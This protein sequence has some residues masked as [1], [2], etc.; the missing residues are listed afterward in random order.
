LGAPKGSGSPRLGA[1]KALRPP[2][3]GG[4]KAGGSPRLTGS[5]ALKV[6]ARKAWVSL[7]VRAPTVLGRVYITKPIIAVRAASGRL[8]S[9]WT[10]HAVH[11]VGPLKRIK[12]RGSWGG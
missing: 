5:V 9:L 8:L 10:P 1:P 6:G 11:R 3:L 7:R 4:P 12:P 2:R